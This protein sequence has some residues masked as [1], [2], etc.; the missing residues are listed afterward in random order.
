M[1]SPS[2][3]DLGCPALCPPLIWRGAGIDIVLTAPGCSP[4]CLPFEIA[5]GLTGAGFGF[6]AKCGIWF[7]AEDLGRAWNWGWA[8]S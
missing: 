1:G 7:M 5:L 6:R 8:W 2:P 4:S 3:S